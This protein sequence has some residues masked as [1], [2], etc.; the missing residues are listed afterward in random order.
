MKLAGFFGFLIYGLQAFCTVNIPLDPLVDPPALLSE[1]GVLGEGLLDY[2]IIQP[3][4]VDFAAKRRRMFLPIGTK[5]QFSATDSYKFPVG[6]I[7]VKHFQMEV[8][9]NVFQN[10]ETRILVRKTGEQPE[11][12]VGYTYHW[13][14][15]DARL[16]DGRSSPEVIL[17]I[18]ATAVGGART[19]KFKIPSRRQCLQCHNE[20]VGFVRSFVTRQLNT[21]AQLDELSHA[22]IFTEKLL[23]SDSYERYFSI[24]DSSADAEMRVKSYLDVNCAHC[25]NP[26]PK[27]LCNFTGMDFRYDHFST[28]A[29]IESGHLEKGSKANSAIFQRMSSVQPGIRMPFIGTSLRDEPALT[30]VGGWID[31]LHD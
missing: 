1:T 25:H 15:S 3:L 19:Q 6:S 10:I 21:G 18:D 7:F 24:D 28:E 12:W 16:V 9:K 11:N 20:S 5:I 8:S 26:G 31:S 29:L 14:G 27:A 22:G 23:P 4:W 13:E 30:I 2:Q 17:N